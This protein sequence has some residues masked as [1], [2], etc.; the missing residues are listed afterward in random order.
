MLKVDKSSW[1]KTMESIVLHLKL[2][3]G[4][5][6]ALLAYNV[7]HHVKDVHISPGYGTY[8]NHDEEMIARA[9][10]INGKLHL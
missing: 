9:L 4:V 1:V 10:I 6:G 8:L 5:R 7:W 3:M 2:V